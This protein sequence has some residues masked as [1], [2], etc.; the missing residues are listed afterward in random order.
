[1]KAANAKVE[2]TKAAAEAD[3]SQGSG[4]YQAMKTDAEEYD[5]VL[6]AGKA[7]K[8]PEKEPEA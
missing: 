5:K 1:M 3:P 4:G 6:M 2:E 8:E 7:G